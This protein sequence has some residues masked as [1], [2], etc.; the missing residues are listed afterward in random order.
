[1]SFHFP[2][3][4]IS[5]FQPALVLVAAH[6][7]LHSGTIIW[8]TFSTWTINSCILQQDK[9]IG[10]IVFFF[11][12]SVSSWEPHHAPR[13]PLTSLWRGHGTVFDLRTLSSGIQSLLCLGWLSGMG[14]K[15]VQKELLMVFFFHV[16]FSF[17][18]SFFSHFLFLFQHTYT[19][20]QWRVI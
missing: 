6:G 9:S 13:Y 19:I 20:C 17:L 18:F 8:V 12:S 1:M 3:T 10:E 14:G 15:K 7:N 16:F 2:M 4:F 5:M 11:L